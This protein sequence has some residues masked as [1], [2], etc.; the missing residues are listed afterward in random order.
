MLHALTA[1]RFQLISLFFKKAKNFILFS[2]L[3]KRKPNIKAYIQNI[4]KKMS[5][6]FTARKRREKIIQLANKA[7]SEKEN[8][9]RLYKWI[10]TGL[11][12]VTYHS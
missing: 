11:E 12:V 6:L 3:T 2:L 9:E 5:T 7:Q 10:N 4:K 1:K 8:R